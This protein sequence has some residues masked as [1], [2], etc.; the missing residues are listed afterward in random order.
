MAIPLILRWAS[1]GTTPS[2]T[3]YFYDAATKSYTFTADVTSYAHTNESY[4]GE[5]NYYDFAWN[6]NVLISCG[7]YGA[8]ERTYAVSVD[9]TGG[10]VL[11][12]TSALLHPG[13]SFD[14]SVIDNT[15]LEGEIVR[16]SSN[17]EVATIDEVGHVEAIAPG[18]TI[19]T[20]S[21]GSATAICVV[22]VEEYN[23]EVL[24]FDLSLVSFDG[25]K[26]NGQLLVKVD[27]LQPAD[28]QLDEIRWEVYED[29]DYTEYAT[30]LLDVEQYSSDGLSGSIYMTISATQ[31]GRRASRRHRLPRCHSQWCDKDSGSELARAL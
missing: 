15:G 11:S 30:G 19:I 25:L 14:L 1:T 18:Q 17:P 13:S 23:T 12:Q 27:N 31:E 2:L 29:E 20:V 5:N 28:V 10:L 7:D 8:N 6:G 9:S 24:D 16:T 21:K 22:A 4:P 26:P 3:E